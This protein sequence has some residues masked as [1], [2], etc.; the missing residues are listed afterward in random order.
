MIVTSEHMRQETREQMRGGPGTTHFSHISEAGD[1]PHGRLFSR[2]EL[3][4]GAG[5]GEHTHHKE[6][7]YY[8]I[9]SGIGRVDESN[10]STQVGPGDAVITGDGESHSIFNIGDSPLIF[11]A[12]IFLHD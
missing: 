3:P 1:I 6:T 11:L 4:Q 10:G 8:Y 9:L 5:I 2:V 7:E 12:V